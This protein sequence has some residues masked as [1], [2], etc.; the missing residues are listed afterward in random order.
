MAEKQAFTFQKVIV[1]HPI[2]EHQECMQDPNATF[3][4]HGEMHLVLQLKA[5]VELHFE[6]HF[7]QKHAKC[8]HSHMSFQENAISHAKFHEIFPLS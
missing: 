2:Y 5:P 4:V 6:M 3:H 8:M 7:P 1:R